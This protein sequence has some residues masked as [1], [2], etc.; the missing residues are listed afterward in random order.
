MKEKNKEYLL[1]LARR[2]IQKYLLE[3][4]ILEIDEDSLDEELKEKRGVFVTLEKNN[5]LRGC[6]G[7]LFPLKPI[8]QAVIDNSLASAFLDNRFPPLT[9]E[10]LEEITI[11]ISVLSPLKEIPL[12]NSKEEFLQYLQKN[13]V[14][15]YF[16]KN[17]FQAT[18]LPQVWEELET[19]Q[20]F[21]SHLFLKGGL[22]ANEWEIEKIWNQRKIKLY[23]YQVENFKEKTKK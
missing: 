9:F 2:A 20:E 12:F 17:G 23:E 15:V 16:E 22:K 6:I 14:G 8:Y 13:K 19:A 4:Q 5:Q 7:N 21:L 10:E 1:S 11:E 18:F 3:K